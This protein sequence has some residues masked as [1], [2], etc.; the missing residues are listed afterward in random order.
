MLSISH[1]KTAADAAAY[2]ADHLVENAKEAPAGQEDYY[3]AEGDPGRWRGAGAAALGLAGPV[4]ARDF[5]AVALGASPAG[6]RLV[7]GAGKPDRRAGWDLV[8]SAPKS[9]SVAWGLGDEQQRSKIAAA[10]R[11]AVDRALI[12]IEREAGV[13]RSR[14]GHGGIEHEQARA[15]IA[16]FDHGTSRAKDPDLHSHNFLMNAAQRKDGSWGSIDSRH[17]FKAKMS[18]G[19]IYRAELAAGLQK[20]GYGIERDETSFRL[21]GST[22]EQDLVFSQRRQQIVKALAASGGRSAKAAEVAALD[23]RA[24]KT[25]TDQLSLLAAWRVRGAERGIMSDFIASLSDHQQR[26]QSTGPGAEPLVMQSPAEIMRDLTERASTVSRFQIETAVYQSAQGILDADQA[27][28]YVDDVLSHSDLIRM[29]ASDCSERYTTREMYELEKQIGESAQRRQHEHHAVKPAALAAAIA[30]RPTITD[31]QKAALKHQTSDTGV[32]LLQ[33]PAGSGK[34]Y[35]MGALNDAYSASGYTLIGAAPSGK[36]ASGLQEGSGIKSQTLHSLLAELDNDDP[37]FRRTLTKKDVIVLDEGGMAGSRL[38][39]RLMQHADSAGAKVVMIGDAQQLQ[40]IDAGG[41]FRL[42]TTAIGNA[43]LHDNRRQRDGW[44]RLAVQQFRDGNAAMALRELEQRGH[45]HVSDNR[46]SVITDMI[47]R[48]SAE[49]EREQA[50]ESILIAARRSDVAALNAAARDALSAERSGPAVAVGD[51]EYQAS[52]RIIFLQNDR[53][54]RQVCGSVENGALAT[55]QRV[56]ESKFVAHTDD[57]RTVS[58][59]PRQYDHIDH[60]YAIT[61]HKSQGITLDHA[62][63]MIDESM[64]DREWSYVAASR[65]RD[66]VHIYADRS[67]YYEAARSMSRSH[68][69]DTSQDHQIVE[70]KPRERSAE[71]ER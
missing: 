19:A 37:R 4:N 58:F 43:E 2:F 39:S 33:A 36:A 59:D 62:H 61:A 51:R 27:R 23:T 69:I 25:K 9:V 54:G 42:L 45:A 41:A 20:I 35:L 6:D 8:F 21:A 57:G 10:H 66:A 68:Q 12:Y 48:W 34:S 32:S 46:D 40:P 38:I 13:V 17:F 44:A 14:R 28:A 16:S 71:L 52:D 56:S 53:L 50:G 31:E 7:Q 67:T 15:V 29:R 55:L 22:K 65:S 3:T 60:G 63:V 64:S 18:A 5:A 49:R 26:E 47:A 30:A 11:A 1:A 24:R 70:Q